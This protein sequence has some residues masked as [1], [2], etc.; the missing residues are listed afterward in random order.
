MQATSAP[1]AAFAPATEISA[2]RAA[3]ASMPAAIGTASRRYGI[4]K[5]VPNEATAPLP[6][7]RR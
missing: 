3:C 2:Q 6:Q 5:N 7:S 4:E 1:V